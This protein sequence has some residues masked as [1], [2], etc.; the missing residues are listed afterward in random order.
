ME[1]HK[2]LKMAREIDRTAQTIAYLMGID[3]R[4]RDNQVVLSS[5]E[6][7]I[8]DAKRLV[9]AVVMDMRETGASW[10]DVAE[11]MRISRQ[12]AWERFGGAEYVRTHPDGG[13]DAT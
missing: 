10:T 6:C 8:R 13:S 4:T 9:V 7:L 5:L 12:G 3:P 1:N 11:A 2:P